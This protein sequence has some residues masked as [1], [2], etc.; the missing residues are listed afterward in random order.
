MISLPTMDYDWTTQGDLADEDDDDGDSDRTV[1]CARAKT[2]ETELAAGRGG[3]R[4]NALGL[5][6]ASERGGN[7]RGVDHF[8][9]VALPRGTALPRGVPLPRGVAPRG[10]SVCI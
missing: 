9:G 10:V 5:S 4:G 3:E 7:P 8:R 1:R 6:R 2:V